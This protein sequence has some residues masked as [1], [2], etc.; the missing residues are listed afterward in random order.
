MKKK[1]WTIGKTIKILIYRFF[2]DGVLALSSQLAYGLIISVFPFLMFLIN[3]VGFLPVQSEDVLIG[4]KQMLPQNAYLLL[5]NTVVEIVD[6]QNGNLL[7]LSLII[8]IWAASAGF[9]AVIRGL[10]KAYDVEEHR[11]FIRVL[12]IT[13]ISTF[14]LA[15]ILIMSIIFLVFG[16]AIG[17]KILFQLG[18]SYEFKRIWNIFRYVVMLST[19]TFIFATLYYYTPSRRLKWREVFPGAIF[20]TIAWIIVSI[21]FSFYVDNFNNYSRLYGSI[22]AVIVFLV[23]LYL[24]SIIIIMGGEINAVNALKKKETC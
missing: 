2:D 22:G 18:F 15:L 24:T 19:T 20:A 5:H 11:S 1:K 16:R 13:I 14:G 3:L 23:W 4:M 21:G 7:S 6:T 8:T 9:R 17:Q 12:F 10:N